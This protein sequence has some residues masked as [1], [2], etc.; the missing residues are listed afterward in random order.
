MTYSIQ[1]I[2]EGIAARI[3]SFCQYP[4]YISPT[5][6]SCT[7]PCFFICLMPGNLKDEIDNRYYTTL[8]LDIVFLQNPNIVN[9]SDGIIS[10]LEN[11]DEKL[12]TIPYT[13]NN[14]TITM[15][16]YDRKHHLEDMD[17]HYQVTFHA[18]LMKSEVN[19]YMKTLTEA[20]YVKD[21]N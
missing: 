5:Q 7:P 14:S 18:R 13:E 19:T 4:I 16:T 12:D 15:Y 1:R 20:V 3:T 9:A 21:T 17:L 10:V 8:N 2:I 11:L 6:Q